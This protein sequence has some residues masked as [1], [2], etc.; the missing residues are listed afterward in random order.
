MEDNFN[1]S[2]IHQ[3]HRAS[4]LSD[5]LFKAEAADQKITP[6]Q[7]AVLAVVAANNGLSQQS[8]VN[9]TGIDRSTVA[10]IV[11]RMIQINL[12][13][14]QRAKGNGNG[15]AYSIAI[16]DHGQEILKRATESA[17]RA[18]KALLAKLGP[19]HADAFKKSLAM[20]LAD[21]V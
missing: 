7:C 8:I 2:L 13:S 21:A 20:L 10:D 12:L 15:R 19:D 16:T 9:L 3:L 5:E 14:R 17:R 1:N 18:E 6:R 4:Q 11:R